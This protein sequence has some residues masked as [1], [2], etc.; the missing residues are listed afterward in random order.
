M[1]NSYRNQGNFRHVFFM[2]IAMIAFAIEDAIIKQLAFK[3]PISQVLISVGF[4]G[5]LVLY[6]LSIIKKELIANRRFIDVKFLLRMLCELISSVFFVITM[7]HVSLIVSSALLQIVPIMM[8][9]GG[10]L[11]FKEPVNLKQWLLILLGLF[12]SLLVI[13]PGADVFS[14]LSLFALAGAFFL[15]LRDLLTFS[16]S[17]NYSPV[18]IAFWGFASLALGGVVG[19]P[20][21]GPFCEFSSVDVLLLVASSFFGP[22]A[23]LALIYATRGGE[24][25]VVAPFRYSR[26]P[27][28]VLIG[29]LVF[30]EIPNNFT[31]WGCA[32]IVISGFFILA[33][34]NKG[35]NKPTRG[36]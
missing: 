35:K 27:I 3:L 21:F 1:R 7:V 20:F 24:I 29:V 33:L 18:A 15:T 25:G 23:Y 19:I 14:P 28:A 22:V 11:L 34:S 31:L 13:Q 10:F 9:I 26:L 36:H 8:T 16:M 2:V 6:G 32:L 4:S 5:L 12:G 30:D 17:D